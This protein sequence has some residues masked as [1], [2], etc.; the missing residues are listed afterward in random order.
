MIGNI[1][2]AASLLVSGDTLPVL[3]QGERLTD[4]EI[5]KPLK[6]NDSLINL[7]CCEKDKSLKL[8]QRDPE[9]IKEGQTF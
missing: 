6:S 2:H 1:W 9:K 7:D 4:K 8:S 3:R 5:T